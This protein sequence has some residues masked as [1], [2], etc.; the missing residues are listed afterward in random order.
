[1]APAAV[2]SLNVLKTKALCLLDPFSNVN[3]E[4][5]VIM[6]KALHYKLKRLL[7][8]GG[9]TL[10]QPLWRRKCEHGHGPI[11]KDTGAE[12]NF[13]VYDRKK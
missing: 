12:N 11:S 9:T 3:L 2:T 8:Q 5:M 1:M 7:F 6:L 10:T 13:R 4:S